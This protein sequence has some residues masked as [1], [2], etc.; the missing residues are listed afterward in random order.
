MALD[1]QSLEKMEARAKRFQLKTGP[2]VTFDDVLK[3]Y[4]S[5]QIPEDQRSPDNIENRDFRL[6]AIHI[7]G[8]DSSASSDDLFKY[9]E[10]FAPVSFEWCD[11]KSANVIW[12]IDIS[13]GKAMC[14]LSRPILE[15]ADDETMVAAG[16]ISCHLDEDTRRE[17]LTELF[18]STSYHTPINLKELG[19]PSPPAGG[20]WRIGR[21]ST[22]WTSSSPIFMRFAMKRDDTK[23]TEKEIKFKHRDLSKTQVLANIDHFHC[24]HYFSVNRGGII[25][26]TRKHK[27]KQ[28]LLRDQEIAEEREKSK[29][30]TGPVGSNPWGA[31][32][33]DWAGTKKFQNDFADDLRI[34]ADRL[35]NRSK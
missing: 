25:S 11:G 3:V 21:P 20:T 30:Y 12:A 29:K 18:N 13:A 5:L 26:S 1:R 27:I 34:L 7:R 17:R 10:E 2:T 31:I 24:L 6:G 15:H 9:F 33:E 28:A 4:D 32:A 22:T 35:K 8:I 16:E 14:C 19:L 23:I